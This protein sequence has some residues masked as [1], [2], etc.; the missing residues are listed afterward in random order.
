MKILES[1]ADVEYRHCFY[2]TDIT[3]LIISSKHSYDLRKKQ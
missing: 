3:I 2:I 1:Q